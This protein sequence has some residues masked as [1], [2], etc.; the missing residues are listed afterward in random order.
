MK[1]EENLAPSENAALTTK[2]I[3]KRFKQNA[4]PPENAALTSKR[5][6]KH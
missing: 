1:H 5:I 2:R 3:V 4:S 6:M